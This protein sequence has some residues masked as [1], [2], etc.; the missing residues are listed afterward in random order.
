MRKPSFVLSI[1]MLVLATVSYASDDPKHVPSAREKAE[2]E[3]MMKAATP[4]EAHK[5]LSPMV[6][7]FDVKVKMWNA[8]SAAPMESTG[9]T[10]NTW[11]LGNRW[12]AQNFEGNF[13]GMPFSGI[14]Y[15]G[16]DNVRKQYV[17]TWMDSMSTQVMVGKGTREYAGS[18]TFSFESSM[19][20]PMTGK[21]MPVK[22]K[23]TVTDDDHHVMEMWMPA[24]NGKMFKMMEIT[25]VR[26]GS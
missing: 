15:T 6:G 21:T 17:G 9:K 26:S 11:V 4:G 2:M 3:A 1:A 5:K 8:P 24:P 16:Y 10:V 22:E 12:V 25:Y 13:M 19:A 18:K 7:T 23:V 20:D 14:G